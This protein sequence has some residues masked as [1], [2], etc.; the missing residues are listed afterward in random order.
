M[1]EP[2][3]SPEEE[4]RS[5]KQSHVT[6]ESRTSKDLDVTEGSTGPNRCIN[7]QVKKRRM[8]N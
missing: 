4:S 1:K 5:S 7:E 2:T 8:M 6:E 3:R